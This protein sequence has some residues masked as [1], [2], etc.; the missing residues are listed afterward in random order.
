MVKP[1][2]NVVSIKKIATAH[3]ALRELRG[4]N[5]RLEGLDLEQFR[6]FNNSYCIVTERIH[7]AITEGDFKNP[8]FID[9][10][11]VTF[12]GYYFQAINDITNGTLKKSS[13]WFAMNE[14]ADITSPP[15]FM[16]CYSGPSKGSKLSSSKA[17]VFGSNGNSS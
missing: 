12:V 16:S 7:H 15:V 4:L 13:P 8:S 3:D 10:F 9:A 14:Y 1:T 17:T 2:S 5:E 11:I 6:L